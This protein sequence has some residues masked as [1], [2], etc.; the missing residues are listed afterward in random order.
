TDETLVAFLAIIENVTQEK[1]RLATQLQSQKLEALGT[2]A[3]GIAH[4]FNNLLTIILGN[5][6]LHMASLPSGPSDGRKYLESVSAAGLKAK[7]LGRQIL[8]FSRREAVDRKVI[9][10]PTTIISTLKL[11]SATTPSHITIKTV[12]GQGQCLIFAAPTQ[13]QQ[14]LI[15]LCTNA[16]QAIDSE[17]QGEITIECLRTDDKTAR[18]IVRDNGTGISEDLQSQIFDPFFTTKDV[19]EGTGLGLAVV[20]GIL[21][22]HQAHIHLES[23]EGQ[24]CSFIIDFP[25]RSQPLPKLE[26]LSDSAPGASRNKHILV[27][28][29]EDS[30]RRLYENYLTR[31]GF[32]VTVSPNGADALELF[33]DSPE[34][35]NLV[36]TD[37]AMPKMTG[38]NLSAQ[39][40]KLYP[41]LPIILSTGFSESFKLK[42]ARR[43]GIRECLSKPVDLTLLL[44]TITKLLTST[45]S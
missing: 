33:L 38:A 45:N 1:K 44:R 15:N 4:E 36:L 28:E 14:V 41:D 34:R 26:K 19:G 30:I 20:H 5:T 37:Q 29:D 35:Y 25:R 6:K 22:N 7:E 9:D 42:D 23:T 10:L 39:L 8:T 21:E 31:Q 12:L 13:I 18:L 40:L 17:R 43:L 24:G 3:G 2:L 16:F 32:T 11:L 27:V